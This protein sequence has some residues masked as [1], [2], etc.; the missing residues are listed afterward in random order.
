MI[1]RESL[2]CD[3]QRINHMIAAFSDFGRLGLCRFTTAMVA[4]RITAQPAAKATRSFNVPHSL[5]RYPTS[6]MFI[7]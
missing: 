1:K 5:A 6:S 7:G 3:L 2:G 4:D